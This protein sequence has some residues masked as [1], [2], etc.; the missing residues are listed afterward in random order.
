MTLDPE[1]PG[2]VLVCVT[3]WFYLIVLYLMSNPHLQGCGL[4]T[5]CSSHYFILMTVLNGR[6][7]CHPQCQKRIQR[8]NMKEPVQGC[9]TFH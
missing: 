9:I 5:F 1:C 6:W 4:S 2:A 8:L 7:C 3:L